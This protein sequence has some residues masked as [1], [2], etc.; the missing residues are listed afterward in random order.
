MRFACDIIIIRMSDKAKIWIQKCAGALA[1]ITAGV[2]VITLLRYVHP[3]LFWSL[4]VVAVGLA[5][6]I[7][8]L[9][10]KY[11]ALHKL[12]IVGAALLLIYV[13]GHIILHYTGLGEK[14]RSPE[15]LIEI[16]RGT[17]NWGIVVFFLLTL[18]QVIVLPIPAAVT[19]VAGTMVYGA[20]VSFIVSTV[21]T[22]IGSVVCYFLGF[23]FG[24]KLVVWIAGEE[25]TEKYSKIIAEKGK[26]PFLA[27]MLFPFFPDDILCLTA[28]LA[29]MP[30]KFFIISI[31]LTRPVMLALYSYFGSDDIL[32][33]SFWGIAA[34][35]GIFAAFIGLA[36]LFKFGYDKFMA[37]RANKNPALA[38]QCE[39]AEEIA[40]ENDGEKIDKNR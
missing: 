1:A 35:V 10:Q 16:I 30:F 17:G 20:T 19:V 22:I 11:K 6:A 26:I 21:G 25:K 33:Y 27:M 8:F 7:I 36:L 38:V 31:S 40:P 23:F 9:P 32:P 12:A 14:I 34:R 4:I 2:L 29:K 5:A 13:I 28:G 24:K 39:A 3:A 18:L 37:A 15:N